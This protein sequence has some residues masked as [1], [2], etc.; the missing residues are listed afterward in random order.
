MTIV[1]DE[2]LILPKGFLVSGVHAGLK[3]KKLDMALIY[4]DTP[5][6]GQ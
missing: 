1:E 6:K 4:S 2:Q 3:K 5:I